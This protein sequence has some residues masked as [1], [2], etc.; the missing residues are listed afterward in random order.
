MSLFRPYSSPPSSVPHTGSR[1][2]PLPFPAVPSGPGASRSV[3]HCIPGILSFSAHISLNNLKTDY[4]DLYQMHNVKANE[5]VSA[6][7]LALKEAKALGKVK[8]I[9]SK[10]Q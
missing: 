8:H 10:S 1:S 5:D 4:I 6:A 2:A 7:L 9:P 3:L